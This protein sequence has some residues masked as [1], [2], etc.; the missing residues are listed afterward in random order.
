MEI[1]KSEMI[2][3]NWCSGSEVI[4]ETNIKHNN[5]TNIESITR[6]KIHIFLYADFT[7]KYWYTGN[8]LKYLHFC[9]SKNYIISGCNIKTLSLTELDSKIA[10][11][12]NILHTPDP[13]RTIYWKN[14]M[15][16]MSLKSFLLGAECQTD[17]WV[18]FTA[19]FCSI[20]KHLKIQNFLSSNF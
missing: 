16:V 12:L 8:P 9:E 14:N 5:N 3:Q 19:A 13:H 18:N 10:S 15:G 17:N 20:N 7:Y 6:F 4:P 1:T 2:N 11:K